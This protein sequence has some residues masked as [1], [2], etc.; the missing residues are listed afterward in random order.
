MTIKK[1]ARP[2]SG[3][4][5]K[6]WE[7]YHNKKLKKGMHIHHID[8]NPFNNTKENLLACTPEEH[9]LIHFNQGDSIAIKGKFIQYA[10]HSGK[11]HYRYGK[12]VDQSI[13][14]KISKTLKEI[15]HN[16]DNRIKHSRERGG[17]PIKVYKAILIKKSSGSNEAIYKKGNFIGH[18]D[19]QI[20]CCEKLN[21]CKTK[22]NRCLKK[23]Y[24]SKTHKGYIFEYAEEIK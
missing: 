5:R 4:Y 24:G 12:M 10:S 20:E 2:N 11:N 8:G 3:L 23:V 16:G 14:N 9:W 7:Q 6:M 18:Y 13:R 17:K 22:V 19:T 21:V 1:R 15:Y